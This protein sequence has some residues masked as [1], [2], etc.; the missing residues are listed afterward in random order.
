MLRNGVR[1]RDRVIHCVNECPHKERRKHVPV[2]VLADLQWTTVGEFLEY[3][4]MCSLTK[5]RKLMRS[6]VVSGTLWSGQAVK[7]K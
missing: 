1:V 6:S 3:W 5:C 7:W 4:S 2:C